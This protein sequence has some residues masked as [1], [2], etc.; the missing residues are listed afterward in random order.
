M[1]NRFVP[2][3]PA[4]L[5]DGTNGMEALPMVWVWD[6]YLCGCAIS[7]P[8]D[9]TDAPER[10]KYKLKG[11]LCPLRD[12]DPCKHAVE[13]LGEAVNIYGEQYMDV[14]VRDLKHKWVIA[15]GPDAFV[16]GDNPPPEKTPFWLL[17]SIWDQTTLKE[18]HGGI[19][20]EARNR[21]FIF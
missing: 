6:V 17:A 11:E 21:G 18:F 9:L 7:R 10:P 5:N 15:R 4:V 2:I 1:S 12:C 20:D 14:L 13:F 19:Y 8:M 16:D 3:E